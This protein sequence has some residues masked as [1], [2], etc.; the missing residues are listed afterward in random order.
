MISHKTKNG[1]LHSIRIKLYPSYLPKAK[2]TYI[3]RTANEAS[4][5]IEQVCAAMKDRGGFT[6]NCDDLVINVK[7]FFDETAYQLCDGFAVNTGYYSI[8]PN[9]GGFFTS[10]NEEH[11]HRKNKVNFKFR[12]LSPLRNL[13]KHI[14]VNIMGLAEI[15]AYI[16]EFTDNDENS[17]NSFY[18]PGNIFSI[19]GNKI[20]LI[21]DDS[22]CGIFFVPVENVSRA[23]KVQ[24]IA[25]NGPSKLI[26][27]APDTGFRYNWVEVR[28]QYTGTIGTL[29]KT[30]RT[31]RG[32]F[33]LEAA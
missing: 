23:V 18:I 15:N 26:G 13:T 5:S 21:G 30:P 33:I 3:A 28:T 31:I 2:G 9:V 29:L 8:H 11:D 1:V 12:I 17:T 7:K 27:I 16:D 24:R 19:S 6:G 10:V 25:E 20:K 4:L 32:R 14:S 22:D